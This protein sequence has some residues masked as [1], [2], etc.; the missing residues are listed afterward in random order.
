MQEHDRFRLLFGNNNEQLVHL[1][2]HLFPL[3]NITDLTRPDSN[4]NINKLYMNNV[5][6]TDVAEFF[7]LIFLFF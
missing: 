2:A 6:Q 1:L 4:N 5:I 3:V 7:I